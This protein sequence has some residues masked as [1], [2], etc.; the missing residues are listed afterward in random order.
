VWQVTCASAAYVPPQACANN[1]PAGVK[2]IFVTVTVRA[3]IGGFMLPRSTV[4][5]LKSAQF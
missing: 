2:Q 5:A 1:P 3:S 4:M